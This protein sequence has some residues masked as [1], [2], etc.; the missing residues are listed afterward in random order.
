MTIGPD[1]YLQRLM[2]SLR[3]RGA[4]LLLASAA[5]VTTLPQQAEAQA[6][7]ISCN[8][9]ACNAGNAVILKELV[10]GPVPLRKALQGLETW[11]NGD[12]GIEMRTILVRIEGGRIRSHE[13]STANRLRTGQRVATHELAG[14]SEVFGRVTEEEAR[15]GQLIHVDEH[16]DAG[17]F[18]A[19]V[20]ARADARVF[21]MLGRP[22]LSG[23]AVVVATVPARSRD[24]KGFTMH[25]LILVLV[26]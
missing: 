3:L 4:A 13:I 14:S 26:R 24:Q 20:E 17:A 12:G 10:R 19:A 9:N 6:G 1:G 18:L 2:R 7:E 21:S 25:P 11:Y 8:C 16:V 15:V 22:K 23:H 5:G